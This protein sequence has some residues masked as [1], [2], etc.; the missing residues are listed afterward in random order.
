MNEG[1]DTVLP[2]H[3]EMVA[4]AKQLPQ[5]VL[6]AGQTTRKIE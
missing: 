3:A 6:L 5:K 2:L 1:S 4:D